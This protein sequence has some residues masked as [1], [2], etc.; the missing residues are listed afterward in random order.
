MEMTE[1]WEQK[2]MMLQPSQALIAI[3]RAA[4]FYLSVVY[5]E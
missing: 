4:S 1:S 5:S 2:L 3:E